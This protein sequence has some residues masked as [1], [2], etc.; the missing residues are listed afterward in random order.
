MLHGVQE[1]V[2]VFLAGAGAKIRGVHAGN[3]IVKFGEEF[4]VEIQM[5]LCIQDIQFH[6]V[7]KLD[8][9]PLSGRKG[10]A[11]EI[12][13]G[14]GSQS[15][16]TVVVMPRSRMPRAAACFAMSEM[17]QEVPCPLAMEW[18]CMSERYMWVPPFL[19]SYGA[20]PRGFPC[21]C[22]G[23]DSFGPFGSVML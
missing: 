6:T 22:A 21:L 13:G 12:R 23:A 16:R 7:Q 10:K 17:V 9:E 20:S 4:I 18:V 11:A 5:S 8:A 19:C 14:S 3:G 1:S 2:G 15:G